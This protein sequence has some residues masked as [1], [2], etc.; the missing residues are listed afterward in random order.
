MFT[1]Y[2]SYCFIYNPAY[3]LMR[4]GPGFFRF[5]WQV[6]CLA[7]TPLQPALSKKKNA[8]VTHCRQGTTSMTSIRLVSHCFKNTV[9]THMH[10][11]HITS[12]CCT[13]EKRTW[14][15]N[16]DALF[17]FFFKIKKNNNSEG[18][19]MTRG[20]RACLYQNPHIPSVQQIMHL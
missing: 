9:E 4:G 14:D 12:A 5:A 17:F 11:C 16:R 18:W 6:F 2:R 3:V 20:F 19:G 10:F 13:C 7:K 1:P 8:A 15:S